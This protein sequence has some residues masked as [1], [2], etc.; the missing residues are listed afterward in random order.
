M[1]RFLPLLLVVLLLSGCNMPRE[2]DNP[3]IAPSGSAKASAPGWAEIVLAATQTAAAATN[4]INFTQPE[5][6][7]E[8]VILPTPTP[9][10]QPNAPRLYYAQAGDTLPAVAI[11]FGVNMDEIASPET[12]P[13]R[14]FI[15]PDQ[16]LVIPNRLSNVGSAHP[17]LPDSE[18]VYSPSAIGFDTHEYI[19]NAGGYLSTY[20]E[21]LK[22]TGNTSG[23]NVIERL[24]V[25]NSINPRL[26]LAILEYQSGWVYG[27][28]GNLAIRDYPMGV[29]DIDQK[30]LYR[31]LKWAINHLSMGYYDWREGRLTDL[32]FSDGAETRLAPDLN[33]GTAA[34][35]YYYSQAFDSV[36]WLAAI[37]PE[38]GFAATYEEMFGSPWLR[39]QTVEPLFPP[40]LNQPHMALPFLVGHTWAY[41]GGPHGAWE[42]DGSWAAID[43][44]PSATESGCIESSEWATAAVPGLVVRSDRG[45]V[46]IDLDGDGNEQS[47]WVLIYLHIAEKGRI[48]L[49][50]W[51]EVGDLIGHPSCE[52]GAAT[53]THMH[54]ARKYNGEW[55]AADGPI[56]FNM[57]GWVVHKGEKPYKGTMTR[58][59]E[60]VTASQYCSFESRIRRD[61]NDP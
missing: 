16:L 21:Y 32:A 8:V 51:V 48:E 2:S 29:I 11:R 26:L 61:S 37:D 43:F 58:G 24:A 38:A 3:F 54:L 47:G 55:I 25:E 53:G 34:I 57:G 42:K 15:H 50:S 36:G 41:T 52:G 10:L 12:L 22:S 18:L 56:S 44:A 28:P 30:G 19:Q 13:L 5:E 59:E 33:A 4:P 49:G 46:A 7:E 27:Q 17:L 6:T 9:T 35:Q 39:A 60:T 14:G 45:V 23:A 20:T 40:E 31:Q 1:K